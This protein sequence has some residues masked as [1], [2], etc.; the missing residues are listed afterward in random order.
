MNTEK[1]NSHID[2]PLNLNIPIYNADI[3]NQPITSQNENV[4]EFELGKKN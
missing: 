3:H 1:N 4:N 2:N